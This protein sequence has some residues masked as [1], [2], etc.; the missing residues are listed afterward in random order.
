M[1]IFSQIFR[2]IQ[3]K[4]S[5]K[6]FII[7]KNVLDDNEVSKIVSQVLILYTL[8]TDIHLVDYFT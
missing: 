1:N 7:L 3:L 6:I 8:V 4:N 5:I 2:K